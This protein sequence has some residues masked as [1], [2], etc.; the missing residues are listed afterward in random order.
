MNGYFKLLNGLWI[1]EIDGT[2]PYT[3]DGS[4]FIICGT[5]GSAVPGSPNAFFKLDS[6]FWTRNSDGSGPYV[7]IS[8][9]QFKLQSTGAGG[10]S[11]SVAWGGI[12]GALSAQT[13]L[14][15]AL[16]LKAPLASPA[17]T[18]SP[19]APT[20]SQADNSTK[21]ATTAYVDTLGAT[22]ANVVPLLT[23]N[24]AT[25]NTS[26]LQNAVSQGGYVA[27]TTPGIYT[28]N[29]TINVPSNTSIYI[30]RGVKLVRLDGGS[31][32]TIFQNAN[33][34]TGNSN[35]T[36]LGEGVLYFNANGYAA[37]YAA[38]SVD[39]P[40]FSDLNS[41]AIPGIV[42]SGGTIFSGSPFVHGIV[43]DNVDRF[44][45]GGGL[46]LMQSDKYIVYGSQ[47]TNFVIDNLDVYS[48]D[49]QN[50]AN[51]S[52]LGRDGIHIQGNSHYGVIRN[53][54]GTVNDDGMVLNTRDVGA[55]A[56]TARATG[57]ISDIQYENIALKNQRRSGSVIAL[58]GGLDVGTVDVA[59][60]NGNDVAPAITAIASVSGA[61]YKV[62][63]A[64]AH[65]MVPGQHFTIYGSNPTG[66]NTGAATFAAA[67]LGV[68]IGTVLT[69][70]NAT[71]FTYMAPGGSGLTYVG[72]A[73][74]VRYYQLANLQVE[75]ARSVNGYAAPTVE[76]S[77][78]TDSASNFGV[79]DNL[80]VKNATG[81][82]TNAANTTGVV[83][84]LLCRLYNSDFE[85]LWTQNKGSHALFN[86][87]NN[88]NL[89]GNSTW[90]NIYQAVPF[91]T[92]V[93]GFVWA[94]FNGAYQSLNI[95]GVDVS[96]VSAGGGYDCA[97][98]LGATGG[99]CVIENAVVRQADFHGDGF[100]FKTI[101]QADI[102]TIN[103]V[104]PTLLSS[105][106]DTRCSLGAIDG[107]A[108]SGSITISGLNLSQAW[109]AP[110]FA[111]YGSGVTMNLQ[112]NRLTGNLS[113]QGGFIQY[114]VAGTIPV[115]D[116]GNTYGTATLFNIN[117]STATPQVRRAFT[118]PQVVAF[119]A[120]PSLDCNLGNAVTLS[121]TL[122]A[123]VTWGAPTNVPPAGERV[124][125]TMVQDG[126]GGRAVAWNAAYIFPTAWTNT[127]NTAG[128][129][130]SVTFISDGTKLIAAGANAWY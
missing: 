8:A 12:T 2:G 26:L 100:L 1:S 107:V 29:A 59:N 49:T 30:G 88:F 33:P 98:G 124:Q 74:L 64:A 15:T 91:L 113:S 6:G 69:A 126:T 51:G 77:V 68:S 78:T 7:Q 75:N 13:D 28:I 90:K 37:T 127:G 119:S 110:I 54:R 70:V 14:N 24:S 11:G 17:L 87:S 67:T 52:T 128:K 104:S 114:F 36:I 111:Y 63:T 109:F 48:D 84:G 112:G 86:S 25:A 76:M 38:N 89:S 81:L 10:G 34:T 20:Q 102:G 18:G 101:G 3:F 50:P 93:N 103:I 22:K 66:F 82:V 27:I 16:G 47:C 60:T 19:T 80:V 62:T 122:T 5:Q 83:N 123:G 72:S 92:D 95:N 99:T 116:L 58:Y 42:E 61:I 39:C 56:A 129:T 118:V 73:T 79:I 55:W 35:I 40:F 97:M 96:P 94:A 130:S 44:Y 46:T 85:L 125:V 23:S 120:T 71:N 53:I 105:A 9:G 117:S 108:T 31:A 21:L 45:I 121:T 32:C 115:N 41:A 43:M 57:N 65:K 4:G 106:S